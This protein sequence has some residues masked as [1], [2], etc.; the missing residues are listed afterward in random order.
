MKKVK[1]TLLAVFAFTTIMSVNAQTSRSGDWCGTDQATKNMIQNKDGSEE[2][3]K[4]FEN[5]IQSYVAN[6]PKS[7]KGGGDK[8]SPYIIP[9][10][11]H[12]ITDNGLGYCSKA[13]VDAQVNR[14]NQDFQRINLDTSSTRAIFK[15]YAMSMNIEFRLAH[16][17]PAGNCTEG[18]VRVDSPLSTDAGNA[19]KSVSYWDSKKY[20]N[21]W[22]VNNINS[23]GSSGIILGYAQFP[24]SGI[25]NTYG[26]VID[27][28]Y[29]SSTDR[30]LTHEIG[31]CFGLLHTF[32]SGCGS[33]C[34][35]TGDN[36]CDTP[37]SFQ[38][39]FGCD[40]AQNT[41]SNDA[42]GP[43]AY[44]SNV[45]DQIENY[46][47][48]DDCQ[49]MFT[50]GQKTRMEAVLNST[51]TTTGLDQLN[52]PSNHTLTGVA[53]P[54]TN[55]ICTPIADFIYDKEYICEGASVTFTDD[56]YNA[57]PTSWNWTFT[58][59]TPSTSIVS[60]PTIMYSAAGVFSVVHQPS[61]TA[62]SDTESKTNIITVSSLVA[63]YSGSIVDGFE[64]PSQFSTDWRI[65]NPEGQTWQT[66]TLASSSGSSSV[67]IRNTV[68]TNDDEIDEL[69]S[70]S[71]DVSS[72]S[73]A[74]TMTFK[75][76]FVKK[77]SS[78]S[79]RLL[80]YT[81]I[82][83]G[84]SWQ[85]KLPLTGSAL[86]TGPNQSSAYVPGSSDFVLRTVDLATLASETNVRFKF[87][88]ESGGGNDIYIDDINIGAPLGVDDFSNIASFNIYPNPT[89][90]SAQIS[91]NLANDVKALSIKVR[92]SVGQEVTSV[93][94]KQTF[95]KGKYTLKIDEQRKL[96]SG[97]Y[98]IEFNADD[99]VKVQKLIVQ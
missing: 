78:N 33:S 46:M 62:G 38:N 2:N 45:V 25:N 88:F 21:I 15:P 3:R 37:P 29:V 43:S 49:N 96:A 31:H 39:T 36:V 81:S 74:K 44:S 87:L 19:V 22:V 85:L 68:T 70:S 59:G 83:C 84:E 99:N 23:S 75:Q 32:Q 64:S 94:N 67:R 18:I 17:D 41:C 47:S 57:T 56:S 35:S 4:A 6:N 66:T 10:V 53:N 16:I 14:L 48:Y 90:S 52:T 60:N 13:S 98:F 61:T 27:N 55:P 80:V 69:I 28:D 34:S 1:L 82:D 26:V 73:T 40:P 72:I 12:C 24:F 30:T 8:T 97:I 71:F 58:G 20:F 7:K 95:S 79:D 11:F 54:Y 5:Y 42:S 51:S 93:I 77:N 76:A 91:F 86:T 50:L 89:N 9:L 92:N 65:E 63:D